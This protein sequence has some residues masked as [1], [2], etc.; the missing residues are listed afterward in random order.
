MLCLDYNGGLQKS[1][2]VKPNAEEIAVVTDYVENI[3]SD[4]DVPMETIIKMNI[5]A[6]E[7]FS[8]IVKFSRA[9]FVKIL[10]YTLN[11]S[12]YLIFEDDGKEYNPLLRTDPDITLSAEVREIGG[13]GIFMVKKTMD[14]IS[15][16][17]SNGHNILCAK[18]N[19]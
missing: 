7:I 8:N 5:V 4:N 2:P 13:L 1:I 19:L 6:D 16:E 18:K 11:D 14:D 15:Y 10:C 12:V 17:Y 9:S 3:L